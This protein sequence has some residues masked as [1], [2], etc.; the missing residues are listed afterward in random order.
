MW[1]QA[2][3][4]KKA[5][6]YFYEVYNEFIFVFKKLV[7]G[8]NTSRLSQEALNFLNKKGIVEEMEKY[9]IISNYCS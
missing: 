5:P 3:S 8:G 9:N 7:F 4:R 2:L 6:H 1:Y